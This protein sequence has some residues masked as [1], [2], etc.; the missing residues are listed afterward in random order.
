MAL[1]NWQWLAVLQPCA[2]C[3]DFSMQQVVGEGIIIVA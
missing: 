1:I 3:G 2:I